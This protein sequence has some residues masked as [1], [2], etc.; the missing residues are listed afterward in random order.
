MKYHFL[1]VSDILPEL[2]DFEVFWVFAGYLL[3]LSWVFFFFCCCLF[4]S[5]R[6]GLWDRG[7][8]SEPPGFAGAE[9]CP[10]ALQ[11]LLAQLLGW[12]MQIALVCQKRLTTA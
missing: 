6:R 12:G 10:P 11:Q 7:V 9:S 5:S 4:V 3:L 2:Q 1:F 8:L